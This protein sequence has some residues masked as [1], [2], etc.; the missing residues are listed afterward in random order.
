MRRQS[1]SKVDWLHVGV[2]PEEPFGPEPIEEEVHQRRTVE[3]DGPLVP[4]VPVR[5]GELAEGE[6]PPSSRLVPDLRT[7]GR[8]GPCPGW[9]AAQP[10]VS[11]AG[12]S[13]PAEH[14]PVSTQWA[15]SWRSVAAQALGVGRFLSRPGPQAHADDG[16]TPDAEERPAYPVDH[17]GELPV[18]PRLEGPD[19]AIHRGDLGAGVGLGHRRRDHHDL[20]A[21]RA[22]RIDEPR[23]EVHQRQGQGGEQPGR[24]VDRELLPGDDRQAIEEEA[25]QEPE[26]RNADQQAG[27]RPAAIRAADDPPRRADDERQPRDD[28]QRQRRGRGQEVRVP[29]QGGGH[30]GQQAHERQARHPDR[31]RQYREREDASHGTITSRNRAKAIAMTRACS[32]TRA[33]MSFR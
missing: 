19:M 11:T 22:P 24:R 31:D 25:R 28:H 32:S 15:T 12:G 17:P 16:A 13:N 9:P 23:I 6:P 10:S 21:G 29:G 18:Q 30:D 27:E 1:D 7:P 2:E 26:R 4:V 8:A 3:V 20:L 5:P 33:R 14:W